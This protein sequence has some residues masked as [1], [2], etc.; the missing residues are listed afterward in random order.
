MELYDIVANLSSAEEC[1]LFF[2]DLCSPKELKSMHN[3]FRAAQLA[4][5]GKTYNEIIKATGLSSA[6]VSRVK[7]VLES[8]NGILLKELGG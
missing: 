8:G 6:I 1:K 5:E 3:R 7:R 4:G 2:E